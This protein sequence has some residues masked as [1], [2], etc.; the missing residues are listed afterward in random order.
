MQTTPLAGTRP[1]ARHPPC[2]P[3][4]LTCSHVMVLSIVTWVPGPDLQASIEKG[5]DLCSVDTVVYLHKKICDHGYK[6]WRNL[7]SLTLYSH[8]SSVEDFTLL[9]SYRCS[10]MSAIGSNSGCQKRFQL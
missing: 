10:A 4:R 7:G 2:L 9:H 8:L 6:S 5:K 1:Q 3:Q